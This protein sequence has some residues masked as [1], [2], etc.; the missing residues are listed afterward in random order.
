M[1]VFRLLDLAPFGMTTIFVSDNHLCTCMD[2]MLIFAFR[3][4]INF[5]YSSTF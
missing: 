5:L 2:Y 3:M 4:V 1:E